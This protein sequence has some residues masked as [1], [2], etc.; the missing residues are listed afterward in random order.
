M[1]LFKNIEKYSSIWYNIY[2]KWHRKEEK[3]ILAKPKM[4][5]EID[6]YVS[7][8]LGIPTRELMLRAGEAVANTVKA[9]IS[10][11]GKV[12]I[13]V[14]KGNNG[15]D[16][17]ATALLLMDKY[18]IT[19]YDVFGIGQRSD[20]G[21]YFLNR[22]SSLGGEV[23]RLLFDED[24]VSDI[25]KSDCI[26]D[27][28]FGTGFTGE[29]PEEAVMLAEIF[30]SL[31][32]VFKI[33]IDVPLGV[34]ALDGSVSMNVIYPANVTLALGFVKPGLVSYPAKEYVGKLVYDNIG[35][36]NNDVISNFTFDDYYIDYELAS[37]FI[38]KRNENSN[39]GTFGKLLMITGSTEFFGAAHLTLEA[40]LRSGVGLVTYLG[41]KELIQTLFPKFPEAIYKSVS[42]REM[43]D[44]DLSHITDLDRKHN[45]ILIGSGSSKSQGLLTLIEHLLTSEGSPVILDADAINVLSE[46][47][48]EGRELI[49]NSKRKVIL[50]PHPLEFSRLCGIQT[51]EVQKNRI[52]LAKEFARDNLCI[53]ILKGAA[54]VVTD[55][56]N[57]Y[58]NS[59]GSSA[60]AKAGSGDV[61]AG[62]LASVIASGVEPLRA[63]ALSVY[64]HG[65]AA[66]VLK[67]ELSE[68]GVTSSDLPREIGR[69][70]AKALRNK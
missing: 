49:R 26:I 66:D 25:R 39:K 1:I 43:T 52:A 45:A 4:I 65:L 63:A 32:T 22:F 46:K 69:Q 48:E 62:M 67:D 17:Y 21:K 41:E 8:K 23:K 56:N 61:L 58:I 31:D 13:F 12:R 5:S 27:A 57:T 14:G 42:M 70:I 16:G 37:S 20:D 2:I 10:E 38:P 40:A 34:N 28:V 55:G 54:T 59:S 47:P 7:E 3:M 11:G 44:S 19:V 51:E 50:T 33:A 35:L 30:N 9:S 18:D 29:Y 24:T 15:G 53:L 68:F 6:K 36:Q 64:F 60:L